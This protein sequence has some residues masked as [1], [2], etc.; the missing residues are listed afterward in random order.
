MRKFFVASKLIATAAGFALCGCMMSDQ[1][2]ARPG[3]LDVLAQVR[4][5]DLAAHAPARM[6]SVD[7][8]RDKVALKGVSYFGTDAPM[9]EVARA[10]SNA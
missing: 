10:R 8:P 9:T 7:E 2:G 4:E 5:M 6:A 3:S 1:D